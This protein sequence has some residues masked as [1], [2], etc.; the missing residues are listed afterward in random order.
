MTETKQ[1][2]SKL[3][4]RSRV[5]VP[6]TAPQQTQTP[7]TTTTT[8]EM[9]LYDSDQKESFTTE[10]RN[11]DD[12]AWYT[13]MVTIEDNA[14]LRVKFEKFT[15]DVDQLFEPSFLSSLEDLHDF[16]KRFRPLSLQVQDDECGMLVQDVMVCASRRFGPD[17]LRFYDAVVDSVEKRKHSRKKDAEC[18][19]TFVLSWLH[20]PNNG[21]L[22]AAEIGDICIIQPILELDPAV[23]T[24]L[25]IART[26]IESQSGQEIVPYCHKGIEAENHKGIAK[27]KMGYFERMQCSPN[28]RAKRS[29]VRASP[30]VSLA[31]RI[32]DM[33][34]EGKRNVCMMLIGNLDRELCPSTA[35]E[36]LYQ[37]T[38]VTASVFIFPSLSTDTFTR[39]A[40]ML[41]NEKDLEK[42]GDF[43]ENPNHMITSSAGRPWVVIEKQV[44]LENIKASIGTLLPEPEDALHDGK[45]RKSN[46]LKIV[47]SGTQEFKRADAMR[48]LYLEF[49]EH[50][51]RMHKSLASEEGS[52][53]IPEI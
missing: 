31:E 22:T 52:I 50:Q 49:A 17:D 47:Y 10:F 11:F 36:F 27:K 29:V 39:G 18:L 45:N 20:G 26:R 23:A 4:Q 6:F 51:V 44:G 28:R 2:P 5:V 12:D 37:H 40:I 14:I 43:L 19:C 41:H 21:E 48:E 7:T 53:Y 15:D 8:K 24:F 33:E 30:E 38:L 1:P 13:V 25:E 42:L 32:E 46:N 35:I 9:R 3:T 16:E 34:L